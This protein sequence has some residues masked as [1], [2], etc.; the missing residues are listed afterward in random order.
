MSA[1]FLQIR[2]IYALRDITATV[3]EVF[4]CTRSSIMSKQL[5]LLMRLFADVARPEV[6]H[7]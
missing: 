2:K 5:T 1:Y 7:L 4:A 6:A 3:E